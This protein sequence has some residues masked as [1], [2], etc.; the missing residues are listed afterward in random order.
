M[1]MFVCADGRLPE[2]AG[3]LVG[4]GA[5]LLCDATA[6]V[7]SDAL[8]SEPWNP[9]AEFMLR[10]RALENGCAIA[11]ATKVGVEA[12]VAAYCGRSQVVAADGTVLAM[13]SARDPELLVVDVAV[14]AT[15]I[16]PVPR[17]PFLERPQVNPT[18]HRD[19]ARVAV[20]THD[21]LLPAVEG[22]GC[23]LVAGPGGILVQ[24]D[25]CAV[26]LDGGAALVPE[27]A[28]EAA[29]NGEEVLVWLARDVRADWIEAVART[30]AAE[31][32]VFVACWRDPDDGGPFIVSPEGRVVARA[33]RRGARFAVA[34]D[35]LFAAAADKAMAPGTD[36][37]ATIAAW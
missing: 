32:R 17:R 3:D 33:P 20:L 21:D 34:A 30:R 13:A 23:R 36:A 6:W 35:C 16:S 25:V 18:T 19:T 29:L 5:R 1:G 37:F 9:Q 24:R 12:G 26:V 31:N 22:H 28:R 27:P 7:T 4:R 14:P 15:P 11:A 8:D 2:I 10:V